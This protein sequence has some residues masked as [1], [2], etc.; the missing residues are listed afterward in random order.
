MNAPDKVTEI[1]ALIT[2]VLAALTALWGWLGWAV[3]IFA[4]CMLADYITGSWA[5]R[6]KGEWSSAIARQG[7]WHKLGE[8]VAL[9]V[10]ALC[11]IAIKVILNS[12]AAPLIG[13]MEYR[14]YLSMIVAIWYIFTEL[15]SI[16]ENAAKLGAPIPGWLAKGIAL[17]R[18]RADQAVPIQGKHEKE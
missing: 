9:L 18:N 17:L 8:I 10:A 6:A 2:A 12:A 3:L 13:D 7:L 4:I 5:A 14:S 11:D 15:G 16:I 1:K